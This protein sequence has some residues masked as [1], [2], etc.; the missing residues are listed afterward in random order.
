MDDICIDSAASRL[1][2]A[3]LYA[4]LSRMGY[5]L[6]NGWSA[7]VSIRRAGNSAGTKVRGHERGAGGLGGREGPGG[8]GER[9]VVSAGGPVLVLAAAAGAAAARAATQRP[10]PPPL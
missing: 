10:C 2:Q 7:I 5:E 6:E 1:K 3:D 8:S 9:A 4:S